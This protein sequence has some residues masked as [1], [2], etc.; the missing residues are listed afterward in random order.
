[1]VITN[2]FGVPE[3]LVTLASRQFYTKGKANYSVTE[4]MAPPKIK[5]LREK[6]DGQIKQ[7]VS[8]M[9]WNLLGS[10]L[11]VVMERGD[12]AGWVMEERIFCEVDGVTISGAIDLQQ[13]TPDG[14]VLIDYKFTSAWAVMQRKEEWHQQLNMYKWLVETVKRKKVIGLKI[15]ALVRD[16][17]RHETKEGY[18]KAPIEIVDIPMWDI[19]KT[20]AY[21]RERLNL[22][23]DA[24]V[25]ADFGDELPPCSDEERWQSETTYAVKRDGR[26]TA[27]RVFKSIDEAT[28]L[29]EKEKGYVETRLGEPRRCTGN[30]CGVADWCE[31]YQKELA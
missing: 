26:K 11:H 14:I 19:V 17:S 13:E 23:R 12:T 25:A 28:A 31:Q 9:L 24:K 2:Q 15:C 30:Y 7:D 10:A 4:I 16:F 29:A 5:R 6:Y 22:H 1:M 3:P 8:D 18:P 20:E 27:I 21:V